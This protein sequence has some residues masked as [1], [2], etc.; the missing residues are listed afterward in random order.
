MH[1]IHLYPNRRRTPRKSTHKK[2]RRISRRAASSGQELKQPTM[3]QITQ[4]LILAVA[5]PAV[6][7][8]GSGLK[9][10]TSSKASPPAVA[11]VKT[12]G[13]N[14]ECLRHASGVWT[15]SGLLAVP[16]HT[17]VGAYS[18]SVKL[19]DGGEAKAREA[20]A[21]DYKRDYVLLRVPEHQGPPSPLASSVAKGEQLTGIDHRGR[22]FRGKVTGSERRYGLEHLRMTIKAP[23]GTPLFN[24][25]GELAAF[26]TSVHDD[27]TYAIVSAELAGKGDQVKYRVRDVAPR[28]RKGAEPRLACGEKQLAQP[29][30][31][32]LEA[33]R[34]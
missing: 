28:P 8:I 1:E 18:V 20:T 19:P 34:K 14:G 29:G 6:T 16:L 3:K 7:L 17:L 21:Y 11:E 33:R 32:K 4:T 12:T 5:M 22:R 2:S 31:V 30:L 25:R 10:Q 13:K 24:E 9:P 15:G 26:V 27:V 23:L